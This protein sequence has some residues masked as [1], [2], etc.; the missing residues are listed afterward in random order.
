MPGSPAT[1]AVGRLLLVLVLPAA[2]MA[3]KG[4]GSAKRTELT[5]A[6]ITAGESIAARPE[7]LSVAS[8]SM[9]SSSTSGVDCSVSEPCWVSQVSR[10][11]A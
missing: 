11:L 8:A 4:A 3:A 9:F 6:S 2:S 7:Y 10:N 1:A 5:L